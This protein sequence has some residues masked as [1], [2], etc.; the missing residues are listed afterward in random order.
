[1]I[2]RAS[3]LSKNGKYFDEV[4]L[5]IWQD[6]PEAY[7]EN[8]TD[9]EV[10]DLMIDFLRSYSNPFEMVDAIRQMQ[11]GARNGE[12]IDEAADRQ[13]AAPSY[14]STIGEATY[15]PT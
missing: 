4:A 14:M 6:L 12:T 13:L 15:L 7:N 9:Q 3:F 5:D 10:R 11:L 8:H 2:S 1:M